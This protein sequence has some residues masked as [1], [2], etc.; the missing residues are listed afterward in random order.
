MGDRIDTEL[1]PE[2]P[3]ARELAE[4]AKLERETE[5]I[6]LEVEQLRSDQNRPWFISRYFLQSIAAGLIAIP[7]MWF[8]YDKLVKPLARADVIKKELQLQEKAA[9]LIDIEAVLEEQS[10]Y[11]QK[12]E[13]DLE[14][15]NQVLQALDEELW[16][17]KTEFQRQL[18]AMTTELEE[19]NSKA[20][21]A[22]KRNLEEL[23]ENLP[24]WDL[25][26]T[27]VQ[28]P[29]T[30]DKLVIN[31]VPLPD[32]QYHRIMTKK[33]AIVLHGIAG[34]GIAEGTW[35]FWATKQR[36][37][38]A[39]TYLIQRDG[40][41]YEFFEPEFYAWHLGKSDM[42]FH[43]ASI[44]V[45]LAN[46]SYLE[47]RGDSYYTYINKPIPVN[48]VVELSTPF[49]GHIYWHSTT[50]E[51]H[52]ALSKLLKYL[53]ARFEIPMTFVGDIDRFIS[54]DESRDFVGILSHSN[55]RKDKF[56]MGGVDWE[57]I[58][59]ESG[60]SVQAQ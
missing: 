3:S 59:A 15:A 11:A 56:D 37:K 53:T 48:E 26:A 20:A 16:Q 41:V 60:G 40:S 45:E 14:R 5:K 30:E 29:G 2:A 7:M 28:I 27:T 43:K 55:I 52:I 36:S 33:Q 12:R 49:R 44:G 1:A 9:E 50:D 31:K 38:V 47:R 35:R 39:A 6:T 42:G 4:I 54:M 21:L 23:R 24:T 51:Q 8:L 18:A 46:W 17:N 32:D 13:D 25:K 19:A 58:I 57:R 34:S 22:A 10:K